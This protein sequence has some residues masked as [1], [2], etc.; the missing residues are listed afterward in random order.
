MTITCENLSKAF[1][2]RKVL[3]GFSCTFTAGEP[4]AVT[5]R[6]GAGKTT[7]LR[8]I[9]GLEK[10]D[11][12]AVTFSG[13]AEKIR[14]GAVFQEDRLFET[15]NAV[16]NIR[17]AAGVSNRAAIRRELNRLLPEEDA[18]DKPVSQLSGGQRRRVSLVRAF[19]AQA[20]VLVLDEPFTGLDRASAE[21]AAAYIREKAGDRPLIMAV[22]EKDVP[23]WCKTVSL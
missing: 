14:F 5:G 16:E 2:E 19:M 7:L 4:A 21:A 20:D 1:G 8:I 22:H 3:E 13:G 15:L 10:P 12:G 17:L 6:S 11:A 18:A 9:M 23:S